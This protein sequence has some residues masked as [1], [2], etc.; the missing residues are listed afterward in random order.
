[1]ER[2]NQLIEEYVMEMFEEYREHI[3][4]MYDNEDDKEEAN[5]TLF[6]WLVNGWELGD[7]ADIIS[8]TDWL[9]SEHED[10]FES[11][12]KEMTALEMLDILNFI[13][14]YYSEFDNLPILIHLKEC[15]SHIEK[16]VCIIK[17]YSYAYVSDSV[18]ISTEDI[19]K[20]IDNR[21]IPK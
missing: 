8:I 19:L 16:T 15:E 10:F 9:Q 4:N 14:E 18:G 13:D 2:L 11:F 5:N 12:L 7:T 3:D 21:I 1:M 20:M 17:Q 6:N